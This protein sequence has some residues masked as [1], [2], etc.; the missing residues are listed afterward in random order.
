MLDGILLA[1]STLSECVDAI[2]PRLS[3]VDGLV[4]SDLD[5]ECYGSA[6]SRYVVLTHFPDLCQVT[7]PLPEHVVLCNRY[8]W[9]VRFM[10]L[11]RSEHGPDAGLEQQAFQMLEGSMTEVD[12]QVIEAIENRVDSDL[13]ST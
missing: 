4:A 2:G 5:N 12:W 10:R 8:Y 1:D 9:F 3:S 6:Y 11:H 7:V 13:N